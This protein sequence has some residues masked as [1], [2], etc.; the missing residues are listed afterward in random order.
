MFV[1]AKSLNEAI[2]SHQH[3][4]MSHRIYWLRQS[5]IISGMKTFVIPILKV[6]YC[7]RVKEFRKSCSYLNSFGTGVEHKSIFWMIYH[8]KN[9]VVVSFHRCDILN[10]RW[11]RAIR[12][13]F[14]KTVQ[15]VHRVEILLQ[16]TPLMEVYRKVSGS[17]FADDFI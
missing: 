4:L 7:L 13:L 11:G 3:L 6:F 12:D 5:D 9:R 2:P 10:S 8:R 14:V 17:H 16:D 1:N 15:L